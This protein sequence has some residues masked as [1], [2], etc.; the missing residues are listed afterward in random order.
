MPIY[1]YYCPACE[2]RYSHL[3]RRIGEEAPPCPRCGY[4]AVE[5]LVSA[6]NVIHQDVYH[7]QRLE[8]EASHVSDQDVQEISSFLEESGRLDDASGVYGSQAYREL[9][10]RRRQ[11]AAD[12]DLEDLVDDLT[13][14]MNASQD[15]ELAGAVV[16]SDEVENRMAAEGPPEHHEHEYRAD[17]DSDADAH[18]RAD[19]SRSRRS[20]D[21]LGWA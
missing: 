9:L 4:S 19:H 21:N 13:A 12:E 18:T 8:E 6:A 10:Y 11:G 5:R 14:E 15:T 3:A 20:A 1:E 17:D 16:F 7:E 2:G